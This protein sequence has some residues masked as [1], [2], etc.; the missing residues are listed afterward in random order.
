M[1]VNL[2]GK[3]MNAE[4]FYVSNLE[5]SMELFL[6]KIKE[7][8]KAAIEKL[9]SRD[10]A[11]SLVGT[12]KASILSELNPQDES[13][14]QYEKKALELA[15]SHSLFAKTNPNPNKEKITN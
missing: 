2:P 14:T 4:Q 1:Y 9:G 3:A 8:G 13:I 12:D 6:S 15:E 11:F 10:T 7:F 5:P